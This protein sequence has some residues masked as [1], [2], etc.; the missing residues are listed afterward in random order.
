ME[1]SDIVNPMA[2]IREDFFK[3]YMLWGCWTLVAGLDLI[4]TVWSRRDRGIIE[5]EPGLIFKI[6]FFSI[7]GMLIYRH[8]RYRKYQNNSNKLEAELKE[9]EESQR[10]LYLSNLCINREFN[11]LCIECCHFSTDTNSCSLRLHGRKMMIQ[12]KGFPA[13]YCLYW[14]YTEKPFLLKSNH[15]DKLAYKIK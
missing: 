15:T 13:K 12:I 10:N 3:K 7:I 11:T 9:F 8:L 14:N 2:S 6:Y 4:L 5:G 1:L